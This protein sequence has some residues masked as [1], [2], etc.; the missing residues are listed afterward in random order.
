MLVAGDRLRNSGETI[1]IIAHGL[2]YQSE[3]AFSTAFK[4][5]MSCSPRQF[6][7]QAEAG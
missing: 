6:Q 1:A 3:A 5:T 2:G 7:R 4:R